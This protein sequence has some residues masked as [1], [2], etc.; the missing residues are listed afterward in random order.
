MPKACAQS[1][2]NQESKRQSRIALMDAKRKLQLL[3]LG[4]YSHEAAETDNPLCEWDYAELVKDALD[5]NRADD[6]LDKVCFGDEKRDGIQV[7]RA[8][9]DIDLDDAALGRVAERVDH[10]VKAAR[11]NV[12]PL[13]RVKKRGD[14]DE[15]RSPVA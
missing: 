14:D 12:T 2:D 7:D 4:L 9:M 6:L 1:T 13:R 5:V 11:G 8:I 15:P 3:R 10:E